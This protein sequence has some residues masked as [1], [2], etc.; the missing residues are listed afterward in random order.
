MVFSQSVLLRHFYTFCR[1]IFRKERVDQELEEE[2]RGYIELI[3]AEKVRCGMNRE[4]ALREA[5][6]DVGGLEQVK[7]NVRDIRIGVSMDTLVQDLRYAIRTLTRNLAFSVVAVVT[8]A[9]GIGANTT[10]F[11][12]V[13]GVLLRPLPYPEPDRLLMLWEKQLSDGSLQPV[14]PANFVDW[15]EQSH[16]FD[17]LAAIDPFPDFILNGVGEPQR[18]TGA[19]V[20]SEFFSLLG[21]RLALGRSF[22]PKE[23]RPGQ[24]RVVPQLLHLV[25]AL[26]RSN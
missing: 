2:I 24:N 25:T 16:S 13:N 21:V 23:D 22:L 18:L 19:A 11:T 7:E 8:L 6:R 5:R 1:N 3:A 14:A 4:E 17:K 12:V 15:R 20:S 9:L 10:M 26:W